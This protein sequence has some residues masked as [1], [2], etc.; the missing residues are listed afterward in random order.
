MYRTIGARTISG[1]SAGQDQELEL[2][3]TC[4][5]SRPDQ[6]RDI[7]MPHPR[8]P[9]RRPTKSRQA[10]LRCQAPPFHP[11]SSRTIPATAS[12]SDSSGDILLR[13]C[14]DHSCERLKHDIPAGI[15]RCPSCETGLSPL[16]IRWRSN[17]PETTRHQPRRQVFYSGIFSQHALG[18]PG[19][20]LFSWGNQAASYRLFVRANRGGSLSKVDWFCLTGF[21]VPAHVPSGSH[22]RGGSVSCTPFL[23]LHGVLAMSR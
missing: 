18:F 2:H 8:F 15:H 9:H 6:P 3:I 5:P 13:R 23:V 11:A 17:E 7:I 10:S 19:R 1:P 12:F 14:G 20:C 21:P 16:R 22:G 4:A